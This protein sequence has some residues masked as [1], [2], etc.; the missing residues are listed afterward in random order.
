MWSHGLQGSPLRSQNCAVPAH[1]KGGFRVTQ[2]P[3][4]SNRNAKNFE[5][6]CSVKL[7]SCSVKCFV[8][9]LRGAFS[10]DFL[11]LPDS[12]WFLGCFSVCVPNELDH[13]KQGVSH[14]SNTPLVFWWSSRKEPHTEKRP[15]PAHF[16]Y[17][18][19]FGPFPQVSR[20]GAC[21]AGSFYAPRA[22][23]E[24]PSCKERPTHPRFDGSSSAALSVVTLRWHR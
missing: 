5:F 12:R 16:R 14:R 20:S 1:G 11:P 9:F 19:V 4:P 21:L 24:V 15:F 13:Q 22:W 17:V 7:F 23:A 18:G 8:L 6:S 3:H 2:L 10:R